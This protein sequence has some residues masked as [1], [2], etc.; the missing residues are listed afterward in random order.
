M[1]HSVS[2]ASIHRLTLRVNRRTVLAAI[3]IDFP[4]GTTTAIM[5]PG[6]SGKSTLMKLLVGVLPDACDVEIS[7]TIRRPEPGSSAL[8]AQRPRQSGHPVRSLLIDTGGRGFRAIDDADWQAYLRREGIEHLAVPL[9]SSAD[10]LSR[11]EQ[12]MLRIAAARWSRPDLLILDEPFAGLYDGA[13]DAL[14]AYVRTICAAHTVILIEHHQKRARLLASRVALLAAG[15][16][17]EIA[18]TDTFFGSPQSPHTQNFI[19]TGGC[20]VTS[21]DADRPTVIQQETPAGDTSSRGRDT[22]PAASAVRAPAPIEERADTRTIQTEVSAP[23]EERAAEPALAARP[24]TVLET[25]PAPASLSDA[26]DE[27]RLV[28]QSRILT[29]SRA[30]T[31]AL[32]PTAAPEVR[33]W[34][35]ST[36]EPPHEGTRGRGPQ[37][38]CWMIL[39][40]LAGCP[41]PGIVEPMSRDFDRIAR[42]G[43][44]VVVTLTENA[45]EIPDEDLNRFHEVCHFPIVDME[46][47]HLETAIA[48]CRAMEDH[49]KAG[50]AVVYHCRAGLGRTGTMLVMHLIGRGMQPDDAL[51]WARTMNAYWVQSVAQE[52]F[53]ATL[54]VG[55]LLENP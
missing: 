38:F 42:T 55:F 28:Y 32:G 7:G 12:Q 2:L 10:E 11:A 1:S 19:R 37:N 40:E 17:I 13:E 18:D 29:D 27:K 34:H 33:Y 20:S 3:N 39:G 31:A 41:R 5:G 30:S 4:R 22:V 51:T 24:A 47:P 25:P 44:H 23:R 15:Q 48:V 50:R 49:V 46:A 53:L 45:L 8:V 52:Q 43:T 14:V 9:D 16:L 36:P 26:N 35:P 21:V 54:P 6:G